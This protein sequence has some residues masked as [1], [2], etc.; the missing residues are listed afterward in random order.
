M[1]AK[2]PV[3]LG[4][5]AEKALELLRQ[6]AE[7]LTMAEMRDMLNAGAETQEHFNR[8]VR[9]IRKFYTLDAIKRGGTTVY[10]LGAERA[11][12][13]ADG[14]QVLEK[15][16][17][18]VIHMAH[19]KCQMCGQTIKDDGIKLQADHKIPQSWGGPTELENLWAICEACNRGKRNFFATFDGEEMKQV[20]NIESVHERIAQL[21]R[22]H[23]SD[24]SGRASTVGA[25]SYWS[26]H[27]RKTEF[28]RW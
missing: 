20:V 19:G 27:Q 25:K 13:V 9:D 10:V 8:R 26:G 4:H 3:A 17:A 16:R 22:L 7:G 24:Q 2:K 23:M 5:I 15:L 14:G 1:A 12:P 21:L 18:A 11:A 6:H 28:E